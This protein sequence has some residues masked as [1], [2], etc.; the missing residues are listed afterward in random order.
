MELELFKLLVF[1]FVKAMLLNEI[2]ALDEYN[3]NGAM[4][5][6]YVKKIC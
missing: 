1:L 6:F 2:D 3:E 4:N 5:E